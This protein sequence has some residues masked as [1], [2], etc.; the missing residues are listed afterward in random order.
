[1]IF[2][3]T[4]TLL[5]VELGSI[6]NYTKEDQKTLCRLSNYIATVQSVVSL[7]RGDCNFTDSSGPFG[8]MLSRW[9]LNFDEKIH[10]A[11]FTEEEFSILRELSPNAY[12]LENETYKCLTQFNPLLLSGIKK[13][14][15]EDDAIHE[16]NKQVRKQFLDI[17]KSLKNHDYQWVRDSIPE[18]IN[19][20][21][22]AANGMKI[23][24]SDFIIYKSTWLHA[25][26][27]T[28]VCEKSADDFML[29][30]NFPTCFKFLLEILN[31][32]RAQENVRIHSAIIDGFYFEREICTTIKQLD[33][34]YS[35]KDEAVAAQPDLKTIVFNFQACTSNQISNCPVRGLPEGVLVFLRSFHP[36]IDAVAYVRVDDIPWLVLIQV[37]LSDYKHHKSKVNNLKDEITGCEKYRVSTGINW[38]EYYRQQVPESGKE[39]LKCIYI[40]VS[41]EDLIESDVSVC[42]KP[43]N[44]RAS[45]GCMEGVFFGLILRDSDSARFITVV[46]EK[47]M[48]H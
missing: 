13:E 38:L 11:P 25:E 6:N 24:R 48:F 29:A 10:F 26:N 33:V 45:E 3:D 21:I 28:Y 15:D 19:M 20:L 4:N 40:Y 14:S 7:S 43:Y 30:L 22:Y 42:L 32:F 27:I 36:V 16:I 47:V 5:L 34:L 9:M 46:K 12:P 8:R 1:M 39:G 2:A 37:S 31:T 41:P 18:S 35:Q 17:T 23:P 44:L